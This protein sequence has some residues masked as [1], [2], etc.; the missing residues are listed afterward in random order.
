MEQLIVI[1]YGELTTKKGNRNTFINALKNNIKRVLVNNDYNII[2]N[3]DHIYIETKEI[4][5]VLKKLKKVCGIQGILVAYK[6]N[7]NTDTIK[8]EVLNILKNMTFKT[9]KVETKRALKS[10][11]INSMEFSRIIGGHILKNIPN[12]NVD[13]HK[14]DVLVKIE[15]REDTYIYFNEIKG[16]GGYPAGIQGKGLLM[17][18][19]GIDSP[20]AGYMAL[21]RGIDI[22]CLY[23]ESPPHTSLQ[24]KEKVVKLASILN[25]YSG[26][27]R[28]LVV[29]FTKLQEEIY[30]NVL[31]EYN[32]TILRRMM[33]RIASRLG[34]K[35]LI[36]GESVGQVASQ[37]IDSMYVINSVTNLPI[38]RPVS[39]LDKLEIIDIAKKIGT[40]ETSILPYEDCCTIF[41]PKHPV[42]N[43][44]IEKCLLYENFS[45]EDL[46]EEC[47]NNIEIIDNFNKKYT[48][49]L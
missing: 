5:D 29:P 47:I 37:T 1:K 26:N 2:A 3:R 7:T 44:K 9:F 25:E 12:I 4:D 49:Y 10:F 30:K 13:V 15:I 36:N 42:I 24:A 46:I 14:P 6:V 43:P 41:V 19:G 21:K 28:L 39:C 34:Y 17:L 31:S 33:Y 40:Y 8:E 32:I 35:V 27:V 45:Y 11:P 38:I 23:F 20:V 16:I 22:D 18:S 48:N